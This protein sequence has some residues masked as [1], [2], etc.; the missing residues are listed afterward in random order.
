[1]EMETGLIQLI[2][3]LKIQLA[4]LDTRIMDMEIFLHFMFQLFVFVDMKVMDKEI[5]I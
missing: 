2:P 1:M 3:L 4:K 5:V